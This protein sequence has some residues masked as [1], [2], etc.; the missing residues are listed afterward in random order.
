MAKMYAK[1]VGPVLLLVAVLGL[2]LGDKSL[3]GILNIDIVE[4]LVHVLTGGL[5][6]AVAF[7]GSASATRSVVGGIGAVYVLVGI[8]GFFVPDLLGLLAHDYTVFDNIFHLTLGVLGLGAVAADRG[9]A[10]TA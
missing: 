6:T 8:L 9:G 5:L 3:L 4:D 10:V 2:I 1:V 7:G